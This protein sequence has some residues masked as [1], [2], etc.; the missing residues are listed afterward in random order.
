MG[1]KILIVNFK[2]NPITTIISC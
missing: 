2:V 1:Q